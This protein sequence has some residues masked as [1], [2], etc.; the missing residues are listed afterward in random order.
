[1]VCILNSDISS[2][3]VGFAF[4]SSFF[5]G[6]ATMLQDEWRH[7]CLWYDHDL[8]LRRLYL[9]GRVLVEEPFLSPRPFFL[10]GTLVVGESGARGTKN[11]LISL[12]VSF[13]LPDSLA[14]GGIRCFIFFIQYPDI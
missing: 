13:Q 6:G 10:N 14:I 8:R 2:A 5:S 3:L 1:M 11:S 9:D 12:Q 7:L 4:Y